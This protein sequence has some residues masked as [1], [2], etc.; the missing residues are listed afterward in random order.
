MTCITLK[1]GTKLYLKKAA[2][3]NKEFIEQLRKLE[4]NIPD[5]PEEPLTYSGKQKREK[6]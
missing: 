4:R 5:K 2:S 1:G 3:K 6:S